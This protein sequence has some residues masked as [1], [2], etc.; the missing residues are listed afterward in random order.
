[1]LQAGLAGCSP[2]LAPMS[3][4]GADWQSY[5]VHPPSDPA[6]YWKVHCTDIL[7]CSLPHLKP[8]GGVG[9]A[10][11]GVHLYSGVRY[12]IEYEGDLTG[13]QDEAAP[14]PAVVV[15]QLHSTPHLHTIALT[16][17]QTS[18]GQPTAV[19]MSSGRGWAGRL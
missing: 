17:S 19:M 15:P 10:D 14:G 18:P 13:Q 5:S 4:R 1:M 16:S 12:R 6:M 3:D 11:A 9:L 7:V 8:A 2:C